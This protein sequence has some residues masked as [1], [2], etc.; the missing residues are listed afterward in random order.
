VEGAYQTSP[1]FVGY[2]IQVFGPKNAIIQD[3]VV[4]AVPADPLRN[5]RCGTTRY[6]NNRTPSGVL[7]R[8]MDSITGKKYDDLETEAEDALVLSMFNER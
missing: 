5:E 1:P 3:N 6:F 2:G 7:I 8:G 4:E